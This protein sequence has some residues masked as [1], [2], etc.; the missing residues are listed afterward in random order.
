[1]TSTTRWSRHTQEFFT[2][3]TMWYGMTCRTF[4]LLEQILRSVLIELFPIAGEKATRAAKI[5]AG[6]KGISAMTFGQCLGVL[7]ELAPFLSTQISIRYP[8][9]NDLGTLLSDSDLQAWK[10]AVFLRN[11]LAHNGPGYL[12]AVDLNAGRIW[13]TYSDQK[14]I[15]QQAE[16]AWQVARRLCI[17]PLITICL[18]IQGTPAGVTRQELKIADEIATK[19]PI[20]GRESVISISAAAA[21]SVN[22]FHAPLRL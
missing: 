6:G 18:S 12:D 19:T 21:H 11:R 9:L 14:P 10:R 3:E 8:E 7:E 15:E 1:M 13:R 4:L 20:R 17:S 2:S 5:R 16:E 22:E